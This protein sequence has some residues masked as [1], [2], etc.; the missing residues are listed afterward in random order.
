VG[1]SIGSRG[2]IVTG[3]SSGLYYDDIWAFDP[4]AELNED[5]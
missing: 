4:G 3:S 1:F 2:Y 5:D